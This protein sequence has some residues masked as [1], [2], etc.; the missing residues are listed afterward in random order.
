MKNT[1]LSFVLLLLLC[2]VT[3]VFAQDNRLKKPDELFDKFS[4]PE[5][6]EAYKKV[7]AKEDIPEA[8]IKL[9]D[10]YRF[11]NMPIEA[12]YWYEQ[13]VQ[14][15]ESEPIHKYYYGM[16]L[17]AN[18]KFDEAKQMFLQYA[19]LVPADTRGLRQVESCE[20]ANY[21]LTDPGIY[22][23]ALAASVNSD[24]A[25]FGPAFYK[26]GI[27]YASEN[28]VKNNEMEYN[29][30]EQ[31]F[32]DLFY[33]K[34]E[35]ENPAQLKSPETFKG[36]VNTYLHEGTLT[37]SEDFG[38]MYFT[39][40][41]YYKGRIGYDTEEKLKTVNLQI[42]EAKAEGDK[43]GEIKSLPFNN[44]DYSV[45][46]PALSPDGQA[47][48]FVSDMPG[49]YGG[50]DVYV[51]YK[52]GDNWG[53]PENLG[54][55][56]N[57]EGN[58][59]FPYLA[60]D[61]VL[62]FASDA[63][64]G[65]GG[66]DIFSTKQQG[67]GTWS[68]PENL[69]YPIN[70][71]ADDFA[72][73]IDQKNENGYFSS[74]R[75]GGKGDDDIYSF[76]RLNNIMTGIVVDCETQKPIK[77]AEVE[78]REGNSVLQKRK[79]NAKGTFTFPMSPGKEYEVVAIKEGYDD[80]KQ[81]V[82]TIDVSSAQIDIK[83]PICPKKQLDSDGD[84]IPDSEDP[85]NTDG[86]LGGGNAGPCT[87]KG[88]I[89]DR[90]GTPINGAVVKLSDIS[91]REE[92]TFVTGSDGLYSFEMKGN[93]DYTVFAQKEFYFSETRTAST[94]GSK[95]DQPL[96]IDLSLGRIPVDNNGN[97]ISSNGSLPGFSDN[98]RTNISELPTG[99]QL[100]HI[101]YDF[102]KSFIRDDA[103]PE[104]DK[105][106]R[107]MAENPGIK[108]ELG[109]HTDARG[110]HEY[111]QALSERRAQAAREYLIGRGVNA[112][113]ITAVG[114]G[115][116]KPV[117]DCVDGVPCNN[118]KHQENRRTEFT[119][120]GYSVGGGVQSLPRYYYKSDPHRGKNYYKN[121][122][123]SS[124][125]EGHDIGSSIGYSGGSSYSS[126][127]SGSGSSSYSGNSSYSS[128]TS[129]GGGTYYDSMGGT[130]GSD[131]RYINCCGVNMQSSGSSSGTTTN[132]SP[133][134]ENKT[135]YRASGSTSSSSSY[136]TTNSSGTSTTT[137]YTEPD[138][139]ETNSSSTTTAAAAF[140][141]TNVGTEY[142]IQLGTFREVEQD[143]YA[144]L[145][146]LGNIERENTSTGTQRV[147]I[148]TFRDQLAAQDALYKAQQR[149]F[150][151]AFMVI[152]QDGA[153]TIR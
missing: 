104:L 83:I 75:P 50:T 95:C 80:G 23:I 44:D 120:T 64:P 137:V 97:P 96:T 133:N 25:D 153:R 132:P 146:D 73:I 71:N 7:L 149:G 58:E 68:A 34:K 123:S 82:N 67:D 141:A 2:M 9:A 151:E 147:M 40:N 143:K 78:L 124:S 63:L 21:F 10:C 59:M 94:K 86:P 36:S 136:K 18:G 8:K 87:V 130:V 65:L 113:D 139:Y 110:T 90:S 88:K 61:G 45:G 46:H 109:S 39:R 6:A 30:R 111:N 134:Y 144:A 35:G 93:A 84:G 112:D 1:K 119:I 98:G 152:Y 115:E 19:Q 56:I 101:Y 138:T 22:Q 14:L 47:L 121:G 128:T 117:N 24:K 100:N 3:T 107:L 103:K 31:P 135:P 127:T 20:Q 106:V 142:K 102:D 116:T 53:Q 140:P 12:E 148:G 91:T 114:Y 108:L 28:N 77:E 81:T 38:T 72:F 126:T 62:Y 125:D 4:F 17:K 99:F 129:G 27:V 66:L 43:Y 41:S 79:T 16:A 74:N 13:V 92:K 37:F 29:W 11:M 131:T 51:S 89:T 49:G 48:Y 5:A 122:V 145:S 150:K 52:S 42:F 32:L 60:K 70:T 55:E 33:A 69:R 76:T 57:T 54:P 15:A 118:A 85:D 105:V 26:E